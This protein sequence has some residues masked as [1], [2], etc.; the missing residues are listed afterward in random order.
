MDKFYTQLSELTL[1][2][3]VLVLMISLLVIVGA[4]FGLKPLIDDYSLDYRVLFSEKNP[5]FIAFLAMEEAYGKRDNIMIVIEPEDSNVYTK[6]NILMIQNLTNAAWQTPHSKRV[7][8]LANFQRSFGKEDELIVE[9]LVPDDIEKLTLEKLQEIRDYASA[10]PMLVNRM[11]SKKG[12]V[13]AV[14]I[15]MNLPSD[16][17]AEQFEAVD[18]VREMIRKEKLNSPGTRFYLTG[19]TMMGHSAIE[20]GM[21]DGQTLFPIMFG[22]ILLICYFLLRSFFSVIAVL[23]VVA[24]SSIASLG[25]SGHIGLQ[26]SMITAIVP[27]IILTLAVA[28]SVH[29]LVSM[30]Q[31]LRSGVVKERAIIN[32]LSINHQPIALTSITT[33]IGF[34]ALNSSEIPPFRDMGN[35]VAVGIICAWFLSV[36]TLP[37]MLSYLPLK[38]GKVDQKSYKLMDNLAALSSKYKNEF[39]VGFILVTL[40]MGYTSTLNG[41]NDLFPEMFGKQIT[42]RQDTDF[43]RKNLT[44]VMQIHHAVK[45]GGENQIFDPQYLA[46]LDRL[47]NWY[48]DQPGVLHVE[49]YSDII[50]RLNRSMHGEDQFYY[51]TPSNRELA[52]QYELLFELSLPY[53]LDV[54]HI[55]TTDRS[56]T[57]LTVTMDNMESKDIIALEK[58]G[59]EFVAVN[60]PALD[61]V[62][63]VG[64]S[65]MFGHA[66][67]RNGY[68]T[69]SGLALALISI[70]I[71]LSLSFRSI[72]LGALSLIPNLAPGLFAFGVW[73]MLDGKLGI[74][75]APAILIALGIVVDDTIHFMSKYLRARRDG[76]TTDLAIQYSF[77][78]TGTAIGINCTVLIAG[79][80]VLTLSA[81][82]PSQF[83]GLITALSLFFSLGLTYFV[84]PTMLQFVDRS[85]EAE[86]HLGTHVD[87][88]SATT[89]RD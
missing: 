48:E 84:L 26:L 71:I 42:F 82:V 60:L 88:N 8:S 4:A 49:S 28:D 16:A 51:R 38:S 27:V 46:Q 3:R 24:L 39:A 2:N 7:D 25:I 11:V 35:M 85:D 50:K 20:V 73:G 81:M 12:H 47:T 10:E 75:S 89:N 32:A 6:R 77:R 63:G 70:A 59:R 15:M 83:M 40:F 45:S 56:A 30:L 52:S 18:Y 31:E 66:A 54:G 22:L 86:Q 33:A 79:F 62:E 61:L 37:A 9:D 36:F 58:R 68:A 44:G 34:L 72:K 76:L 74:S 65:I 78:R 57:R 5:Q 87:S 17:G 55:I 64:P 80:L 13:A 29:L 43:I 19:E 53:G 67:V 14:N 23:V 69:L 1:K 21:Y 41:F